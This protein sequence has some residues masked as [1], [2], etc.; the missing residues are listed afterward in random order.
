MLG[1]DLPTT[2]A[3]SEKPYY[4]IVPLNGKH[5]FNVN[6]CFSLI[7]PVR[8][9]NTSKKASKRG[10]VEVKILLYSCRPNPS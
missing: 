5:K 9:L 7:T 10:T 8:E 4:A 3:M 2:D 6:L 1:R